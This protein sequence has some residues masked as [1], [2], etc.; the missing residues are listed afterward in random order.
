MSSEWGANLT[1]G[2]LIAKNGGSIKTGPFGTVLKASEYVSDGVPLISVR[3]IGHGS[4]QI[5]SKTPRVSSATTTRLSEYVLELGDIVFARKGGIERC[6]LVRKEQIGWFLGSDGIRLRP[7]KKCDPRFLAYSLQTQSVKDWLTQNSTGSTMASLNQATIARLP[8]CIPHI[9]DQVRIADCLDS[10]VDR[11]AIL[12]ETNATLEAIAQALFKSWFVDFDPV[13]AKQQARMPEG[14]DEATAALFPDSFEESELGL[15]PSGWQ[16]KPV[17]DVINCV[18]G[19]TPDTKDESFWEPAEHCWTT[20]KDLSGIHSP[21]LLNTE[22][23]LSGKGLAKIG[24][25]LLPVGTLLLSSRAP[26]GYLAIAQVPIAINQ[27]YIAIPPAGQLSPLF[28]LFWCQQNMEVIKARANGSTFMEISKKAF[29][30]IPIL[31]PTNEILT[32]FEAVAKVLFDRI[33]ENEHQANSLSQLRDA[34][35]PRL[36]SGQLRITEAEAAIEKAAA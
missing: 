7:P 19:A 28:M 4:F 31:L 30:P 10:L 14:M 21:V 2:E 32:A 15:V 34:L 6:S 36:I 35:L 24:S 33:V 1:I 23:K 16:V 11:I 29:R 22:R 5:D 3:E 27:G 26:I 9:V 13:R 18:G 20:P 17:G 12:R 25:G 8:I